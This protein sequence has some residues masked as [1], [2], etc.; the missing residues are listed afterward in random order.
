MSNLP[1]DPKH[2][3]YFSVRDLCQLL[4]VSKTTIFNYIRNGQLPEPKRFTK[5]TIRW[6][7]EAV[8]QALHGTKHEPEEFKVEDRW[9][10]VME[11]LKAKK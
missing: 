7:R 8:V 10:Q 6:P 5:R 11:N 2:P 9:G 1:S 3:S 4:K